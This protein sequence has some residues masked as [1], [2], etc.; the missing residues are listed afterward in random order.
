MLVD[1]KVLYVF[2]MCDRSF[3]L[4]GDD[5]VDGKDNEEEE[6]IEVVDNMIWHFG[7]SLWSFTPSCRRLSHLSP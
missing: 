4:V 2:N 6:I 7:Q 3:V 1:M 5:N